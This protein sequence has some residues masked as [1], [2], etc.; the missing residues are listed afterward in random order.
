MAYFV[1]FYKWRVREIKVYS[2]TNYMT[3]KHTCFFF[4]LQLNY[5]KELLLFSP[6]ISIFN[7]FYQSIIF[8]FCLDPN[9]PKHNTSLKLSDDTVY[10]NSS[11]GDQSLIFVLIHSNFVFLKITI[12]IYTTVLFF[13]KFCYFHQILSYFN[14]VV[15]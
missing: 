10:Q 5:F 6:F 12:F 15:L 11:K 8:Y 3:V 9:V 14:W 13:N 7:C 2:Q 4:S 1:F